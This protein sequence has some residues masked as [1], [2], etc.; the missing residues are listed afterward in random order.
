MTDWKKFDD[1]MKRD[2]DK[3]RWRCLGTI[4][5]FLAFWFFVMFVFSR[6]AAIDTAMDAYETKEKYEAKRDKRKGKGE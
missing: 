3:F 4:A 2:Y 1:A 5:V 6:C